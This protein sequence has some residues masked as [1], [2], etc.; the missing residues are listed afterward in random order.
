MAFHT[1]SM[2]TGGTYE[3]LAELLAR[4]H[5][6]FAPLKARAGEDAE[7]FA[8]ISLSLT[9]IARRHRVPMPA[10]TLKEHPEIYPFSTPFQATDHLHAFY[11]DHGMCQEGDPYG[12]ADAG[13]RA[14]LSQ[15]LLRVFHR[16]GVLVAR[17]EDRDGAREAVG[18]DAWNETARYEPMEQAL[19]PR[20]KEER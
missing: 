8:C 9:R 7:D 10:M 5:L 18:V 20:H 17:F 13:D 2:P 14:E 12:R 19:D 6:T 11:R 16:Y 1:G 15:A 4:F 3:E